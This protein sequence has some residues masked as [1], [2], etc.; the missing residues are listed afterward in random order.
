MY[1]VGGE[2]FETKQAIKDRVCEIRDK[3]E[4]GEE[5]TEEADKEWVMGLLDKGMTHIE[6]WGWDTPWADGICGVQVD[7]RDYGT[8]C[9]YVLREDDSREAFSF[10]NVVDALPVR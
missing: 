1:E 8:V 4:P 6:D 5:V 2:Q 10:H 3:Y 9:F 7:R